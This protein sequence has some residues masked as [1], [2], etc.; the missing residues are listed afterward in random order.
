MGAVKKGFDKI[1]GAVGV[2]VGDLTESLTG[3]EATKKARRATSQAGEIQAQAQQEALAA[4]EPAFGQAQGTVLAGLGGNV[5]E[6]GQGTRAARMQQEALLGLGGGSQQAFDAI[7]SSPQF[8]AQQAAAERALER[9][10]SAFGG[11]VS[12]ATLSGLNEL[13]QRLAGEAIQ[14][15]IAN[16]GGFQQQ[17]RMGLAPVAA[18]QQQLG[19][20]RSDAITGAAGAR[21]GALQNLAQQRLDRAGG[22]QSGLF[23]LGGAAI[24]GGMSNPNLFSGCDRRLKE[25]IVKVGKIGPHNIYQFNYIGQPNTVFG[26]MADEVE[27]INP[28]AVTEIEGYKV[29]NPEAMTWQ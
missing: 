14:Q 15:Q 13:N 20:A 5:S 24:G 8:Q 25:N 23:S 17:Q 6:I 7:L 4:L 28:E 29:I 2:D 10:Q 9:K 12:G 27:A 18:L 26:P 19:L 21:A 22:I 11:L 1:G 16:L 3:S